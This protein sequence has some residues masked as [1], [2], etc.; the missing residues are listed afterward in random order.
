MTDNSSGSVSALDRKLLNSMWDDRDCDLPRIQRLVREGAS[1]AATD[2]DGNT[3]L[4]KA[5]EQ[6]HIV[7]ALILHI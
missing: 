1:V 2:E 4:L 3:A 6:Y 5:V 7:A